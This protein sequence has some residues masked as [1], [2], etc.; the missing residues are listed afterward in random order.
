MSLAGADRS[1]AEPAVDRDMLHDPRLTKAT[2]FTEEERERLGLIGLLPDGIETSQ[3]HMLRVRTQLD[4]CTTPLQKY[5]YLAELA[6]R[7]ERL[8]YMM[9]RAEPEALMP[10]VYTPTVGEACQQFGHIMRRPRGLYISL[11]RR[12]R[13]K[14]VLR[15]WPEKDVR[16][17]V[18]TDGERILGLGDQGVCGMGIPI[19]KLALY[20]GFG[21]VPPRA[22]LPVTLDVGTNNEAFLQDP[23]YPGLR[24]RRIAGDAYHAFVD[25]FVDAVQEVFPRC[26]IQ[27][28][29]FTNKTAIPLLERHRDRVCCFNDDIQGTAAVAVAGLLGACRIAGG[30]IRDQRLLFYGA[31]SAAI[32]IADLCALRMTREGLPQD[33]ALR[34]CF[35][36]NSRGLVTA[37]TTGLSDPQRRYA[38][39]LAPEADLLRVVEALKPTAL[40]GV[41]TVAN[42]F[43]PAVIAAMARLNPRPIIFPY[44]NPTSKS[45]CTAR[46]AIEHSQGRAIFAAG[47]PFPP[48]HHQGKLFV[49]GQGNNVYI[50]P[51]IGLA[52]YAT[53]ARRVTDDMFLRAAE[54]LASQVT[55]E[56]LRVGL[57]YPPVAEIHPTLVREAVDVA[58]LIFDSGLATVA[59]PRDIDAFVRSRIYDPSY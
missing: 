34:R 38:H 24:Q 18:V 22:T 25:E 46:D 31:G 41:S 58:T 40:I 54:S 39:D 57:I 49:P 23:L 1:R 45:E 52:V 6:D 48:L 15:N 4:H 12:G 17:I 33:E 5:V 35:L 20:S 27:F 10:I 28:E 19:G 55:E 37:H 7:N 56:D 29:D 9:L 11:K 2:A 32:G 50:Y 47:S 44:S 36:M 59:R 43:T 14:E 26:C 3:T 16:F 13:M 42:A 8:F 30:R 21:G 53:E 51:A